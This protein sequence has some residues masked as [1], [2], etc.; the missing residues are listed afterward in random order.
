MSKKIALMVTG[1]AAQKF[2]TEL[3]NEQEIMARLADIIIEIFAM[4]SGLLRALKM[5][6]REGKDK[7]EHQIAA[8]KIYVDE[9]IPRIEAWSKQILAYMAE[10]DMLKLQL[11]GLKKLSHY[12][13]LDTI[14]LKRAIA[15]E[16]I[17]RESYPL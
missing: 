16:I 8:V 1:L 7:A 12:Q 2:K 9:T 5:I 10:G 6:T 14:S 4:E 3:S 13:P 11:A 15:D 17:E